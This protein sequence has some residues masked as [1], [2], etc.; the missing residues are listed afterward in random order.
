MAVYCML[1]TTPCNEG[2]KGDMFWTK[3]SPYDGVV[4]EVAQSTPEANFA[5]LTRHTGYFFGWGY[6]FKTHINFPIIH[7]TP[8]LHSYSVV[9]VRDAPQIYSKL[10][11]FVVSSSSSSSS[12]SFPLQFPSDLWHIKI[13]QLPCMQSYPNKPSQ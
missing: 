13:L 1:V 5:E 12:S 2:R 6:S 7:E 3:K 11:S 8:T 9:L 4:W 10:F